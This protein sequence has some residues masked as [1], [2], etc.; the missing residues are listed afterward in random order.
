MV[1]AYAMVPAR[2]TVLPATWHQ[3]PDLP[4]VLFLQRSDREAAQHPKIL[5]WV[6]HINVM[7]TWI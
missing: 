6:V 4:R 1:T 5:R 3:A 2:G 7:G